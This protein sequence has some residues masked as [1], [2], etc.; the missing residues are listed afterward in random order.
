[1]EVMHGKTE[2]YIR[3]A[4]RNAQTL[5]ILPRAEEMRCKLVDKLCVDVGKLLPFSDDFGNT[6]MEPDEVELGHLVYFY[7]NG[8][9]FLEDNDRR[10]LFSFYNIRNDVAH[11]KLV[12]GQRVR[13]CLE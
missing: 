12:E 11:R 8:E 3:G 5:A 7:N 6:I 9:L 1:M 4:I 2:E 10:D 13:E